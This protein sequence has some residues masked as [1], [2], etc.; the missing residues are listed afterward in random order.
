[1]NSA[2]QKLPPSRSPREWRCVIQESYHAVQESCRTPEESRR[3]LEESHHALQESRQRKNF[4]FPGFRHL[5]DRNRSLDCLT[6]FSTSTVIQVVVY[7][8]LHLTTMCK[9]YTQILTFLWRYWLVS[10]TQE[11]ILSTLVI[12]RPIS[13][14]QTHLIRDSNKMYKEN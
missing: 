12:I 1:M 13:S 5:R 14:D 11:L 8:N 9:I 10:S 7:F 6:E 3:A 4:K 2:T